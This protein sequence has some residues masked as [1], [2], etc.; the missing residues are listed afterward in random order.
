MVAAAMKASSIQVQDWNGVGE[1]AEEGVATREEWGN[2]Q[3]PTPNIQHPIGSA[4]PCREM[5]ASGVGMVGPARPKAPAATSTST[6]TS[7]GSLLGFSCYL[8]NDTSAL[9]FDLG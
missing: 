5:D 2:I 8:S 6:A 9:D 1:V 7:A 3:H 4:P